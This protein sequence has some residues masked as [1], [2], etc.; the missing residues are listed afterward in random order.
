MPEIKESTTNNGQSQYKQVQLPPDRP[1][2]NPIYLRQILDLEHT[3]EGYHKTPIKTA[4]RTAT[5]ANI[6]LSAPQTIDGVSVVA[7]DRVL[8][9][10]QT[11]TEDN[12]IYLA[13][14]GA[15][16]RALD[17]NAISKFPLC[18]MVPT[19]EGTVAANSVY[20]L[21]SALPSILGT[22][23]ITFALLSTTP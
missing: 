17:L 3:T 12:G 2:V 20:M 22:D 19:S 10:N 4:V 18:L 8:V 16:T 6:T 13:A 7:G 23:T 11:A 15:W 21:T 1:V 9:K 14:A 5:T